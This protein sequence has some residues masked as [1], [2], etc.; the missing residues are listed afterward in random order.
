MHNRALEN[1]ALLDWEI[2][3]GQLRSGGHAGLVNQGFT[4]YQNATL[5][6]PQPV[7]AFTR[8]QKLYTRAVH[9]KLQK[10]HSH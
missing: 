6:V 4:C 9:V 5:Q 8:M 10:K 2:D 3:V 1:T 7:L